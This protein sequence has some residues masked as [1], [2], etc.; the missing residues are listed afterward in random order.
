MVKKHWVSF[1][2]FVFILM[3]LCQTPVWA[4]GKHLTAKSKGE[5]IVIHIKA[6]VKRAIRQ[7]KTEGADESNAK[8]K[9]R[10]T[11]QLALFKS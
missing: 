1:L 8:S 3:S 9:L 4:H 10:V 11:P 7:D 2:I 6:V 5:H